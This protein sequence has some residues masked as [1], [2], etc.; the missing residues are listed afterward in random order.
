MEEDANTY[1]AMIDLYRGQMESIEM[2]STYIQ[3]IINDYMKAKTTIENLE[4][5]K[6]ENILIPVGGGI[7]IPAK[8]RDVS[9]VFVSEGADI[10]IKK[11]LKSA[12]ESIEKRIHMLNES[13][14]QL[15]ETYQKLQERVNELSEKLREILEKKG[16]EHV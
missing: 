7:F 1:L 11:D 10:V 2:Q 6:D 12:K 9:E 3:A 5:E 16:Q 4:K 14:R 13:L 8:C 15:N